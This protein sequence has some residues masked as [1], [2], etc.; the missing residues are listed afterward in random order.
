[1]KEILQFSQSKISWFTNEETGTDYDIYG[2][3]LK[4]GGVERWGYG[5][6]DWQNVILFYRYKGV[7][8]TIFSAVGDIWIRLK[9]S[10]LKTTFKTKWVT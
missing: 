10:E 1:M 7:Y 5:K 2:F 3:S 8:Y 4:Y 9:I 6:Q